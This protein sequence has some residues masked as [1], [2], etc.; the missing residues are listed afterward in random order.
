MDTDQAMDAATLNAEWLRR[1]DRA[2]EL[3]KWGQMEEAREC[4]KKLR[5]YIDSTSAPHMKTH[6]AFITK[7]N[8][9][10]SLRCDCL[11]DGDTEGVTADNMQTLRKPLE[12]CL[13]GAC[14]VFP[15]DLADQ[16]VSAAVAAKGAQA[17]A[18]GGADQEGGT[19]LPPV[20][21]VEGARFLDIR[22]IKAGF[23]DPQSYKNPTIMVS[24]RNSHGELLEP[25]QE[26]PFCGMVQGQYIVWDRTVYA[27][28]PIDKLPQGFTI[29]FEFRHYKDK[30]KYM[31]T[32]CWSMMEEDELNEGPASLELYEKP[33]DVAKRKVRLLTVKPLFLHL[34]LSVRSFAL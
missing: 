20:P 16:P 18:G 14:P 3:D 31:S 7:L 4:Y 22:V 30:G 8:L 27:Q 2:L 11:R 23:K 12:K 19:L 33:C 1:Y 34:N 6:L 29:F 10:L 9:C 32:R 13:L 24:I 21:F 17:A 5:D 26:L 28:T 25:Q 15:F